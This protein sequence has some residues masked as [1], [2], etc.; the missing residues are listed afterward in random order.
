[1]R[2]VSDLYL[3]NE[4]AYCKDI[5]MMTLQILKFPCNLVMVDMEKLIIL[6]DILLKNVDT[7]FLQKIEY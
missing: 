4:V 2:K 1:M 3:Y 5:S 7:F 6:A